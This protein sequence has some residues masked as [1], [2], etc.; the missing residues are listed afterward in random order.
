MD[1]NNY[2]STYREINN[3]PCVFEKGI[4]QQCCRCRKAQHFNLAERIGVACTDTGAQ[5]L[6]R[7]FV[8]TLREKSVFALQLSSTEN[9]K[10]PHAKEIKIQ[11]GGVLGLQELPGAKTVDGD[12]HQL[13]HQA[14]ADSNDMDILPY[15]LIVRSV[16][17]FEGRKRRQKN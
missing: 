3:I 13:L 1:E 7:E 11:C 6:C 5:K 16:V 14:L 17:R 12:V 8:T 4:L 10:L 15:E 2:R 9:E